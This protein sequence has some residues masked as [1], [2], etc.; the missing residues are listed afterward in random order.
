MLLFFTL[1]IE[2]IFY[3]SYD[4][5][6]EWLVANF[7]MED[8]DWRV[9]ILILNLIILLYPLKKVADYLRTALYVIEFGRK[10]VEREEYKVPKLEEK[11]KFHETMSTWIIGA[12]MDIILVML[13]PNGIDN[14]M[15]INVSI[16]LLI[17][18]VLYQAW[19]FKKGK[20]SPVPV[21]V[22]EEIEPQPEQI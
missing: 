15:H 19:K 20:K 18:F 3:Y 2:V 17:A 21:G 4:P 16:I 5:L 14:M 11:A 22:E 6:C 9:M 1:I 7:G 10:N 13:V 12:I 8:I